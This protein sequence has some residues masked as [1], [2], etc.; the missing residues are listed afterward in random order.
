MPPHCDT[1]DGPVVTAARDALQSENVA[2]VLPWIPTDKE[3][4]VKQ[5]FDKTLNVRAA[6]DEARELADFWFF[7]TCV[8]V[9]RI[10]EGAPYTGLKPAGLD[11][12][13]AVEAADQSLEAGSIES[14]LQ[15]LKD[16]VEAGVR[17]KYEEALT[18]KSRADRSVEAGREWVRS[19]VTFVHYVKSIYDASQGEAPHEHE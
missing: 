10:L 7:E 6:G 11:E 1:L 19:Y 12:G 16:A 3:E 17:A 14:V 8:R 9:H 5:A 2:V 15:V 4:E 18:K 13:P